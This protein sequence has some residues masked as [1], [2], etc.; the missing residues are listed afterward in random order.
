[1]PENPEEIER[2]VE[3]AQKLPDNQVPH[4]SVQ[5]EIKSE[6]TGPSWK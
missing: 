5:V 3:E 2:V 1:M 6:Q 4:V